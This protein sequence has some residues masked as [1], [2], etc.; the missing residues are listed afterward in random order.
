MQREGVADEGEHLTVHTSIGPIAA[1]L[2]ENDFGTFSPRIC[3]AFEAD[4]PEFGRVF[5]TK[6]YTMHPDGRGCTWGDGHE[7]RWSRAR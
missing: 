4:H 5:M 3:L 1:T 6:Y 2:Y 7:I